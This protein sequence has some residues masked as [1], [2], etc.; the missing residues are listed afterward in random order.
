MR[1][2]DSRKTLKSI[3]SAEGQ[4]GECSRVCVIA[5]NTRRSARAAHVVAL[6]ARRTGE[7]EHAHGGDRDWVS[8]SGKR[9]ACRQAA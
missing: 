8:G 2:Q 9:G 3:A 7:R 1:F 4:Q 6:R 5:A